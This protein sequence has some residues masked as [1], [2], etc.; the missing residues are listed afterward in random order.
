LEKSKA[1]KELQNKI[2]ELEEKLNRVNRMLNDK[3][4]EL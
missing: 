1:D 2:A 3:M 4:K